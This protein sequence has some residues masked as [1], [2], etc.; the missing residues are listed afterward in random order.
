[1][2]LQILLRRR[3]FLVSL[4]R[5][6]KKQFPIWELFDVILSID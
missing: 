5:Q 6:I 4:D 2:L 1:M 3:E